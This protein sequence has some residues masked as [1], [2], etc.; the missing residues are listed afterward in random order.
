MIA[1]HGVDGSAGLARLAGGVI[2]VERALSSGYPFSRR[3][4]K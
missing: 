1:P 3:K 4:T 2:G